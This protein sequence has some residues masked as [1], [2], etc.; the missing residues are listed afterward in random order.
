M[1]DQGG[2]QGSAHRRKRKLG[3]LPCWR[4]LFLQWR[5]LEL[6]GNLEQLLSI[7]WRRREDPVEDLLWWNLSRTS[8]GESQVLPAELL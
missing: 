1:L 5:E 6:V 3:S 8:I 2:Q 7:L 4:L